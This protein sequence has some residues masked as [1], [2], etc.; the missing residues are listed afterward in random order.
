MIFRRR[1]FASFVSLSAVCVCFVCH[2]ESSA[3][4]ENWI[5][6]D[7]PDQSFEAAMKES[8][9][10]MFQHA[11]VKAYRFERDAE[12][13][14]HGAR[15]LKVT[16]HSPQVFGSVKQSVQG[17]PIGDYRF[18]ADVKIAGG[19]G[20]GWSL[21]ATRRKA[22]SD[23][24]VVESNASTGTTDWKRA[25]VEFRITEGVTTLSVGATLRGG[26]TAWLDNA[27]LERKK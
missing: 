13:K 4:S 20:R 6:I 3:S 26:G 14:T 8:P 1:F 22:D 24:D 18:S 25:V 10:Q 19:D 17:L 15:S 9:W 21:I 5:A 12:H 2:A 27:L 16:R 7:L 11:G 23:F